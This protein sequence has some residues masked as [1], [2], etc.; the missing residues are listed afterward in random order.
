MEAAA[1]AAD[2]IVQEARMT[3]Q[4]SNCLSA[5]S[6]ASSNSTLRTALRAL[7]VRCTV[8][9]SDRFP[10]LCDLGLWF[11][12][13]ST[14]FQS[15]PGS[16]TR[17]KL[18]LFCMGKLSL[19][20]GWRQFALR[21]Q[22]H[23]AIAQ[24]LMLP[25]L[26]H[27]ARATAGQLLTELLHFSS[28][29]AKLEAHRA[30][31]TAAL[32]DR[33]NM[34]PGLLAELLCTCSAG[35]YVLREPDRALL[36]LQ[37]LH[38]LLKRSFNQRRPVQFT[39]VTL[40][41]CRLMDNDLV[42]CSAALQH[43]QNFVGDVLHQMQEDW[44]RVDSLRLMQSLM[45]KGDT[46]FVGQ[47]K[48]SKLP[49]GEPVELC[50]QLWAKRFGAEGFDTLIQTM[51][52]STLVYTHM[53]ASNIMKSLADHLV[54]PSTR[55]AAAACSLLRSVRLLQAR[56]P[57]CA[58]RALYTLLQVLVNGQLMS[59]HL[60]IQLQPAVEVHAIERL[61]HVPTY[62]CSVDQDCPVCLCPLTPE[63]AHRTSC[64]H[65]MHGACLRTWL[66]ENTTCPVCRSTGIDIVAHI[67]EQQVQWRQQQQTAEQRARMLVQH[68]QTAPPLAFFTRGLSRSFFS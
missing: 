28:T 14:L 50:V 31:A 59:L 15:L 29:T 39:S 42:R 35:R 46:C 44:S 52:R 60:P 16:I 54:L 24:A 18:L 33:N 40:C 67:Q 66:R 49:Q 55:A 5:V 27:S 19:H 7:L 64:G 36:C 26:L 65:R 12:L 11:A 61:A 8:H 43:K 4:D 48:E 30:G 63:T 53:L 20:T 51:N 34:L 41:L 32:V 21:T 13:E 58:L 6:S 3:V 9:S 10:R 47:P 23:T 57:S 45:G 2:R 22:L 68:Q 25:Q 62:D 38:V 17:V 1:V 37:T 56:S